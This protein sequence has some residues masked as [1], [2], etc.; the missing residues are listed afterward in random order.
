MTAARDGAFAALD[1]QA[2]RPERISHQVYDRLR[3]A[4]LS[5]TIA[6]GTRLREIELAHSLNVSRTPL[7]EAIARLIADRLVRR[8]PHGGVA[9]VDTA[10]ELHDIYQMRTALEACAARLAAARIGKPALE[11][12]QGLADQSAT[13]P[14]DA[15]DRRIAVNA[16]FHDALCRACD[17]P[18]LIDM[19][20]DLR[21]FFLTERGLRRFD[22]DATKVAIAEHQQII[23][24]LRARDGERAEAIVRHHLLSA[25][26]TV[27]KANP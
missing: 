4:I 24:A 23:A 11:A 5:G 1:W 17:S 15:L 13:L 20:D 9:V 25:W 3:N 2:P 16:A 26:R 19:I 8:L 12:L 6:A 21:A 14:F 7:R 22:R 18:R 10:P 27:R